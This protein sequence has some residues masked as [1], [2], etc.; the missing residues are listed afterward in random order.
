MIEA[1]AYTIAHADFV[2]SF[3]FAKGV[4]E[5]LMLVNTAWDYV[6]DKDHTIDTAILKTAER[7]LSQ[8]ADELWEFD[9]DSFNKVIST[10][11]KWLDNFKKCIAARPENEM[12]ASIYGYGRRI[13]E[14]RM[15]Q[16]D[17]RGACYLRPRRARA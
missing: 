1:S 2:A 15:E 5:S 6:Q 13:P 14:G 16:L 7:A 3:E 17:F 8:E 9:D 11:T 4:K 12:Q 10:F